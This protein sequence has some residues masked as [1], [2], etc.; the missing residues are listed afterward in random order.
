MSVTL[1]TGASSGLGS[2][3]APL[4]AADGDVVILAARRL[5]ALEAVAASIEAAGGQ[6]V[7]LQL[8]VTDGA[9]VQAAVAWITEHY[10]PVDVLVA[11]A[12]IGD[13]T[14]AT[15]WNTARVQQTFAVNVFGVSHCIEAVLPS[16]LARETGQIV[17]IS[18]LAALRGLPGSAGYSAS[19]AALSVLLES[20]RIE[21]APKGVVVT[22][23]HPGF[24]KTPL[25]ESNRFPMPFLV[26]L[27]DAARRIH[28]A[29]RAQKREYS[30]PWQLSRVVR[31]GRVM[32]DALYDRMVAKKRK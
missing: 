12:G 4:F 7:P 13:P 5:E 11:N 1:I 29:V 6:A 24:V 3:M 16:M 30:F 17:G 15:R 14:R 31:T 21:L 19:K 26:E 8:D 28:R 2:A 10:G 23:I 18:S 20:L 32:P 22:T 25:T 27:P 9:A